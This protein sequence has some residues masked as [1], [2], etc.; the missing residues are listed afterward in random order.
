MPKS[1][2]NRIQWLL[3]RMAWIYVIMFLF[4]MTCVDYKTLDMRIKTR[5]L[6]DAI[7]DYSAMVVFSRD[8]TGMTPNWKPYEDY[9]ELILKYIPDD[10]IAKQLLGFVDYYS[11]RE[12]KAIDLLKSSAV[13][14]G[15]DLLWPDYNLGVIYFK[16]GM[17]P[18]AAEY[19]LKSVTASPRLTEI[20]MQNSIIYRQITVNPYFRYSLPDGINEAQSKACILLLSS[21]YQMGQYDK[22]VLISNMGLQNPDFVHKDAFYYYGGLAFYAMGQLQKAFLL[23]QKSLSLEKN[24]PDI[25]YYMASIY[26]NAGQFS[27]ARFFLQASYALHQKH[28]PSFPY[29]AQLNLRFY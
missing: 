28:D 16:K 9:F 27:Q 25:Y 15:H 19:L 18:Q 22:V 5:H 14:N 26:Q 20:L 23:F 11:G 17:W 7:P 24:N 3:G 21:L 2:M 10:L 29:D 12:Q 6:N 1:I 8:Q 13:M 4:V